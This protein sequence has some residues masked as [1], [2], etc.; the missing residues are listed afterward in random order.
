MPQ[1][2]ESRATLFEDSRII[3]NLAEPLIGRMPEFGDNAQ[4]GAAGRIRDDRER[5]RAFKERWSVVAQ[6]IMDFLARCDSAGAGSANA[7]FGNQFSRKS[8]MLIACTPDLL[9]RFI[10]IEF[11]FDAVFLFFGL[12]IV[13]WS[14]SFS[15]TLRASMRAGQS[16]RYVANHCEMRASPSGSTS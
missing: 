5:H 8:G 12:S 7:S 16:A 4:A 6:A 3:V 11:Q 10:Q 1:P 14:I 13:H 2:I 9:R 15:K